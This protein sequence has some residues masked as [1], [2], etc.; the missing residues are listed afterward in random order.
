MKEKIKNSKL[1]KSLKN[2]ILAGLIIVILSFLISIVPCIKTAGFGVCS[3]GNPFN[4]LTDLSN[5]FYG[6][7]NNPMTG[8]IFQFLIPLFVVF[9]ISYNYRKK[10][11]HIVDYT[12]K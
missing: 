6:I 1:V 5:K 3:L 8:L 10:K 11:E 9:I 4:D 12:K 7:S 2:G